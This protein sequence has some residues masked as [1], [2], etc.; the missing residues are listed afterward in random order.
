MISFEVIHNRAANRKGGIN[1]LNKLLPELPDREVVAALDE[2]RF[3]AAISSGVNVATPH[4]SSP[5][6][7]PTIAG[8]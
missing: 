6:E 7:W 3:L 2:S 1:E 5:A 8:E 4:T